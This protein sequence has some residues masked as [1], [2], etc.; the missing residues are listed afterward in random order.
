MV[1]Q[2]LQI[3]LKGDPKEV[4]AFHNKIGQIKEELKMPTN[5]QRLQQL[6]EFNMVTAD[7]DVKAFLA[8]MS[9]SMPG[10]VVT[11][12][13]TLVDNIEEETGEI[14]RFGD[15]PNFKKF[16][17]QMQGVLEAYG[18]VGANVEQLELEA[19]KELLDGL[20]AE[21]QEEMETVKEN[22]DLKFLNV[23]AGNLKPTIGG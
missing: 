15:N 1:L 6:M 21:A 20:R 13:V 8:L 7:Y 5:A 4:E 22:H 9:H 19:E 12:C 2:G 17:S 18:V 16:I 23:D 10:D 11:E 3:P 14:L